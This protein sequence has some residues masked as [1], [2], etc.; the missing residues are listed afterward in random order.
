MKK[1]FTFIAIA[2][3]ALSLASCDKIFDNLEGDL[4]KMSAEDLMSTEAGLDRL[5]ANLYSYI[6]MG[7]YSGAEKNTPNA[8]DSATSGAYGQNISSFWNYTVVRD[9]NSFIIAL[10]SAKDKGIISEAQYK[11]YLGEAHF[12]RAYYYFGSVRAYG[13][14]P[15]VT[16]P[17]DDKFDGEENLGLY[18]P[19]STEK[20]TW[21]FVLSEL[22]EAISLLPETRTSGMYRASKWS[23]YGLK[24]RVA[25]WAASVC[26]H[27]NDA[28]IP[29]T[30]KAVSEKLAFM[31]A[32]DA[33]GYYQQC[34]QAS[35][36]IINSGKFSLYKPSPASVD[37]AV[38]NYSD[39]FLSRQNEEFIF[40]KSY[41][42][43]TNNNTNDYFDLRNSPYQ[44]RDNITQ[45]WRF[46]CYGVTLD[47]VDVYDNYTPAYGAADGTIVTRTDGNEN[48]YVTT[49]AENAGK[50]AVKGIN[51]VKYD[52]PADAFAN[53]DA[54]FKASVIYPGIT[55]RNK[56]INIQGGIWKSDNSIRVYEEA[57]PSETVTIDG[58]EVTFYQFGGATPNDFSGF[59]WLG[60][61]NDGSWYSTGFGIRKF[62]N[63]NK[64]DTYSQTLWY[65][66]RYTEIL[67]NYCEAQVEMSGKNAG[68]SKEYLN[69]IRRRAF[70]QDQIDADIKNVMHE[71]RVELAFEDDYPA[72]LQRRREFFN[73]QR[74]LTA[75]PNGGRKHALVPMVVLLNGEVKYIF[76]RTNAYD[77]DIDKKPGISSFDSKSYYSAIPNYEKNKITVNPVQE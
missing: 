75:N 48:E 47:M 36:A 33:N 72:T 56:V 32:N 52:N 63:Y 55:F 24:S 12:I 31:D 51:F 45:V 71:R 16:E 19:R 9:V 58:K 62:L 28:S 23:A 69:A 68:K 8:N 35:E 3:A 50:N 73:Q 40:G 70:F 29:S 22:D 74:D 42:D 46:G 26:K 25:L 57:N 49:I 76:V 5:L 10:E 39:L 7:A 30:Y 44:V 4:S 66:I 17:L 37:E 11:T 77:Y 34:I 20:A 2:V 53:K 13:G 1:I 59:R 14:V 60:N 41:K 64:V 61:T 27:W 6:P 43:G 54:R 18:I 15:I 65:D 67:L 38:K 21:D